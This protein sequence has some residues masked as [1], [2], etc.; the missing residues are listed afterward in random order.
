LQDF[1]F[2]GRSIAPVYSTVLSQED[3]HS[4]GWSIQPVV[5]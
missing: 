2:H 4:P 5:S 1:E 3:F